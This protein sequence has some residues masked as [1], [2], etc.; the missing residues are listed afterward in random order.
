MHETLTLGCLL[1]VVDP[2]AVM[3]VVQNAWADGRHSWPGFSHDLVLQSVHVVVVATEQY[4]L[5]AV[6]A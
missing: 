3:K 5:S 6:S 1:A 2:L 4:L